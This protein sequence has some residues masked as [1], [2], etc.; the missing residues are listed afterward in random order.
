[1]KIHTGNGISFGYELVHFKYS[2]QKINTKSS[3]GSKEVVVS[4]YIPQKIWV[5]IFMESQG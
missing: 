3:T 5:C 1:M 2:K 4:D